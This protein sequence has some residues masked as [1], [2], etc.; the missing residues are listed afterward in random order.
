MS[1]TGSGDCPTPS[2]ARRAH[3]RP[4][5]AP[6]RS[7]DVS[8]GAAGQSLHETAPGAA[9]EAP[10]RTLLA[11]TI[12]LSWVTPAFGQ[13]QWRESSAE[14][15]PFA[16]MFLPIGAHRSDFK[17]ATMVGAQGAVEVSRHLH[18]VASVGWT[19][20]HNRLFTRDLTDI[21]QYDVGAEFNAVRPMGWGWYLRPFLGTGFGGRAYDYR[22]DATRASSCVAGYGSVGTEVQHNVL[23]FRVEARDYLSCFESPVSGTKSTRNDLGLSVGLAYHPR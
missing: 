17:S 4:T 6:R 8:A 7:H 5:T 1:D 13:E 19:H 21:W 15:R 23:A 22:N 3:I 9:E 18:G 10:M 11:I 2:L 16:G 14:L 12:A 20:G